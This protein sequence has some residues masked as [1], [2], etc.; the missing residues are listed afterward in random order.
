MTNGA[1]PHFDSLIA[2]VEEATSDPRY[3][4]RKQMWTRHNGLEKV[5]KVPVNVHMHAGY[6]PI[7]QELLPESEIVSRESLE[8]SIEIQLRQKLFLHEYVPDDHVL[9]PTVWI[10]PVRPTAESAASGGPRSYDIESTDG[11]GAARLWGLPFLR[12]DSGAAGGAYR[13]DPVIR[14][15]ND[16]SGLHYPRYEVDA[17]ATA[18][19]LERATALVDGRLPIK[20]ATDEVKASPSEVMIS[21]MGIEEVMFDL[22]D[23][24]QLIHR[25]MDFIT[26]GA[27]AYQLERDAARAV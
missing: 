17:A 11:R 16:L 24:P 14:S 8:R 1:P 27:I 9:L 18:E 10:N 13:V 23:R 12:E 6:P 21:F 26:D 4:R 22:I 25:L 15:E 7:W 3:A 20:M 2:D 19:L 5:D